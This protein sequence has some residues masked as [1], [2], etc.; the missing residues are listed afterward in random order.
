M[1]VNIDL[2]TKE[3]SIGMFGKKTIAVILN[4]TSRLD[5]LNS[6]YDE[7]EFFNLMKFKV[8]D[9]L[10]NNFSYNL[11]N[12]KDEKFYNKLKE[13]ITSKLSLLN[14]KENSKEDKISQENY[15][16]LLNIYSEIE[17]ILTNDKLIK[18][19]II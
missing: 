18:E 19:L 2:Y 17:K 9:I 6:D 1:Y 4:D 11:K 14:E 8:Y 5:K 7:S 13:K 16:F 10:K 12:L 15:E 3:I